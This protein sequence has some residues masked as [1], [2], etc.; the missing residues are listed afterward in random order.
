MCL[1][2]EAQMQE[3]LLGHNFSTPPFQA[4]NVQAPDLVPIGNFCHVGLF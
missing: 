3:A 2:T 4:Q 1:S